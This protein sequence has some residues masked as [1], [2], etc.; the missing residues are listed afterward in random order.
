MHPNW[1]ELVSYVSSVSLV[2]VYPYTL[3]LSDYL[4]IFTVPSPSTVTL[5]SWSQFTNALTKT[6]KIRTRCSKRE[7]GR[8]RDNQTR[9]M[10]SR[11]LRP[12]KLINRIHPSFGMR[13]D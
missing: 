11:R 5:S 10:H 1:N 3:S 6:K 4:D 13:A 12:K 7:Q 2:L 8:Y 9:T